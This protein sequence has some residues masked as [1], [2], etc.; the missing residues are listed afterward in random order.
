[1]LSHACKA[2]AKAGAIAPFQPGSLGFD[3]GEACGVRGSF[4]L[5][6]VQRLRKAGGIARQEAELLHEGRLRNVQA[7][8]AVLELYNGSAGAC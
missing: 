3:G 4:G 1:M 6:Q 2:H 5:G 7:V 8:I